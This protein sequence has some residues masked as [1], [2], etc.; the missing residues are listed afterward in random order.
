MK[1]LYFF[2][3][4]VCFSIAAFAQQTTV[5]G[6]VVDASNN[7]P[8][9]DVEVTIEN[10]AFTVNTD[11]EG[12][13]SFDAFEVPLGEQVVSFEKEG[14]AR[15][16]FPVVV[17]E[18]QTL[19]LDVLELAVDVN[20]ENF[21]IGTI[22]LSD[23]ELDN[24]ES[25]AVN[26]SGLL[27]A[28]RDVFLS[29]AAYD[30]SATF[31]RPRGYDSENGKVLINGIE[32]NKQ[33]DGR[34]Q[35]GS[36]GGLNDLQRNQ[37]FT[38]G[39]KAN[40]Y[41]F[42]GISG[43]NNMIMRASQYRKGGRV[44]YA[45]A[46]RSYTNRVMASYSTG[47]TTGG[48]AFSFLASRRFGEEGFT[49]G[50][51]YDANS[52]F[53]SVEKK[54]NEKHSLNFTGFFTPNRRGK[55]TAITDE[56]KDLKGI[57]YNPNWGYVDGDKQNARV[58]EVAEPVLMLN[59][60]WDIS[61]KTKLNTNMAYQFGKIGNTRIDN[62]G[63]RL[64][65]GPNGQVYY[66]GGASNPSPMYYQNLPS[67]Y[68][69]FPDLGANN[70]QSAYLAREEFEN[71]GQLDWNEIFG[72]NAI[73]RR[74]G[75][76]SIYAI[77][78]DRQDD[79]QLTVNTI[80]TSDINEHITLNSSLSYRKLKSEYFAELT[81]LLGGTGYLDVDFFAEET[82]DISS[83]VGDNDDLPGVGDVAQSDTNNPNRLVRE[84]E[85]YKYNYEIDAD[86][87]TGFAQAQFKYNK[88]DFF[89][90]ANLSKTTYQRT[91]LYRN[92]Y[93][94]DN[95]F[96]EGEKL[97]FTNYGIKGGATYKITGRHLIDVN[98]GY[99]T[100]APT[101]RSSYSNA[102]QNHNTVTGLESEKIQ[103]ADL[104]YI[105][106]SPTI[107][108]RLTGFYTQ[109]KD[110]TDVGFY[111]TQDLSGFGIDEGDAFVQEVVNGI[112]RRNIGAEFGIEAQVTPTIKLKAAGSLAQ[113]IYTNN[114]DIYL[115]SDDFQTGMPQVNENRE[116]RF[117]DGTTNL[118]DYHVAGGPERAF[119]LGFEYR[120]P[121]YWFVG[122][123]S[124]YFS[125]AYID[126]SAINRSDNFA[127]DFD[128]LLINDY[129]ED[130]AKELLKQEEFDDYMLFNLVGGKSWKIDDYFVGFFGTINNVFGKEYK[131]GGFEQ[132][133][134]SNYR[135]LN[136]DKSRPNG[137]VFGNRYFFGYGTTYYL[138]FYV[139]F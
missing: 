85:R 129:D 23:N 127:R 28:S 38:M 36:W 67:Y 124:N 24:D 111:F 132:S 43:T 15:K 63:T 12:N 121:D 133:R 72:A 65:E 47:L 73:A 32:M 98:G 61:D 20:E 27:Q 40:E 113:Y 55:S 101:I 14:Y 91:G 45:S 103:S 104:S 11:A 122:A 119:Q 83:N 115:T 109:F 6:K 8:L 19:D 7:E 35:W 64:V 18:G 114:P 126:V 131:T 74:N 110:G 106:R 41:T 76:N 70:Y 79:T 56:V 33:F 139:R 17:N 136:E 48:W 81:D 120:D 69:R 51:F 97:D 78:E 99:Y 96:G 1:K 59:H 26:L 5:T 125:N 30:F 66:E 21:Q 87:A 112:D 44:S 53:A 13:F 9:P 25:T 82:Q 49:K 130:R 62:G 52:F 134:N 60:Y 2:L 135:N 107:K 10:T 90:G 31:F 58:K 54:I 117:G 75:G 138:N 88:V 80:F 22:S 16:R 4:F 29:A 34:P 68:L 100:T 93:F 128:G 92:G 3:T 46:N 123:T 118:K 42:G 94:F 137:E 39:L 57:D 108:A 89:L 86:V 77:Q 105:F 95:S 50:T 71:D 102:R 37:I 116:V 84:G